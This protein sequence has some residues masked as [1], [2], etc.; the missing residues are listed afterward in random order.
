[1]LKGT[2]CCHLGPEGASRR[3]VDIVILILFRCGE[4]VSSL[5]GTLL[6]DSDG[7]VGVRESRG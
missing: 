4:V 7:M 3:L 2:P 6:A 1:M 5:F